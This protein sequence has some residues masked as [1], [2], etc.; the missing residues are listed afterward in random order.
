MAQHFSLT[1]DEKFTML[2]GIAH[3]ILFSVIFSR[4]FS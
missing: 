4:H 1:K 2:S 3:D